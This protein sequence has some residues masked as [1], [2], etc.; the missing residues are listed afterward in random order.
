MK[1]HFEDNLDYQKTAIEAVA[2]LFRG[3]DKVITGSPIQPFVQSIG[4]Q[5]M[6]LARPEGAPL[7]KAYTPVRCRRGATDNAVQ[8]LYLEDYNIC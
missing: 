5:I 4:F 7:S 3:Q 6:F 8:K 1:L 2:D